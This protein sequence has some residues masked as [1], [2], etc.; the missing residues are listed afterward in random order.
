MSGLLR[1]IGRIA[2]G[3]MLGVRLSLGAISGLV[4]SYSSGC[5]RSRRVGGRRHG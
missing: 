5:R 1:R 2:V 3:G 4:D